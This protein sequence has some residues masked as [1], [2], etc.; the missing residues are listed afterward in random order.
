MVSYKHNGTRVRQAL[1]AACAAAGMLLAGCGASDSTAT[2]QKA[3]NDAA[4]R[5]V[6][7]GEPRAT[8]K[9]MAEAG[10]NL[11]A[12]EKSL[13]ARAATGNIADYVVQNGADTDLEAAIKQVQG[14]ITAETPA[15]IK[16]GLQAQL[17]ALQMNLSEYRLGALQADIINLNAQAAQVQALAQTAAGLSAAADALEKGNKAPTS[18]EADTARAAVAQ[19][20]K[21]LADVQAK[22]KELQDQMTQKEAAARQIYADTDA[23]FT[24]ADAQKG[25]AAIAAGNKAMADR[26]Q[27]EALMAEA[28]NLAPQLAR[29]QADLAVGQIALEAAQQTAQLAQAAYDQGKQAFDKTAERVG[30]LRKAA[31]NIVGDAGD[32]DSLTGRLKKFLEL[33]GTLDVEVRNA[34]APADAAASSFLAAGTSHS[35]YINDTKK[36]IEDA[37][38]K[39]DDPLRVVAKDDRAGVILAWSQAESQ[40]QAGRALLAG[41]QAFDTIAAATQVAGAAKAANG[42]KGTLDG[43]WCRDEAAKRFQDAARTAKAADDRAA[44]ANSDL[45]RIKWIGVTLEAT[46]NYG[47]YLAGNAA[48]L[49]PAKAAKTAAVS[50]NPNLAAQLD[51]IQ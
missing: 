19:R 41:A 45:D 28:G 46:A 12:L 39:P 6:S 33:A 47:S 20:Q 14:A 1:A 44:A 18:A 43:K 36:K 7:A 40:Q 27:A 29:A 25:P 26:K 49:D 5:A 16:A 21:A 32:K 34:A 50:R 37:G 24:A 22:A 31:A 48:A 3:T 35:T 10:G 30:T 9:L 4:A 42:T 8:N 15:A 23:A 38:L 2:A 51:W 17:G 11:S 13:A